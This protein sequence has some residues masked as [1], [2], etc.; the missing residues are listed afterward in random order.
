M[1]GGQVDPGDLEDFSLYVRRL[2]DGMKDTKGMPYRLMTAPVGPDTTYSG[3]HEYFPHFGHFQEGQAIQKAYDGKL[4]E[5]ATAYNS[6]HKMLEALALASKK[7]ADN[8]RSAEQ[9]NRA[10]ADDISKVLG[11]ELG[12][13]A[14]KQPAG[15]PPPGQDKK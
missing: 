12:K 2:A 13:A 7:I 11:E 14:P 15:T 1:N 8:Y 6:M 5:V 10:S 3:G 9:L 4:R